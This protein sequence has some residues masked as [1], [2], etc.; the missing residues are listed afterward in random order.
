MVFPKKLCIYPLNKISETCSSLLLSYTLDWII[1]IAGNVYYFYV[2]IGFF[3]LLVC[4]YFWT[5]CIAITPIGKGQPE[6]YKQ[7]PIS[8]FIK[9]LDSWM[10]QNMVSTLIKMEFRMC[11]KYMEDNIQRNC[12]RKGAFWI[13]DLNFLVNGQFQ[14]STKDMW[15]MLQDHYGLPHTERTSYVVISICWKQISNNLDL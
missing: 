4:L 12:L 6:L 2:W 11:R 7:I 9:R 13:C 10:T 5:R 15:S 1:G 14:S 3:F 8:T